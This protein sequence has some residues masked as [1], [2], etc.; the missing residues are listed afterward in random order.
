[1]PGYVA[2]LQARLQSDPEHQARRDSLLDGIY[3]TSATTTNV[4]AS[5]SLTSFI[6]AADRKN[7]G[8]DELAEQAGIT[9]D[10]MMALE[11][12]LVKVVGLP[13][14]LVNR[15]AEL[16][17]IPAGTILTWLRQPPTAAAF[18]FNQSVPQ[19][20]RPQEFAALLRASLQ[21]DAAKKS[22][23]LNEVKTDAYTE[24]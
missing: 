1:M 16:L 24:E 2:R 17:E 13:R 21:L 3:G 22:E 19:E 11:Q 8:I 7:M 15:L 10:I 4:A 14:K 23:W 5:P 20:S 18:H 12:R 9:L 6:E